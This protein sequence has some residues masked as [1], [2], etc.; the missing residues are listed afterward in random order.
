MANE[1]KIR[2][3]QRTII[4]FDNLT[5]AQMRVQ[6]IIDDHR[7]RRRPCRLIILK[8]RQ[9]GF[10]TLI[11]ANA[12]HMAWS[13]P[14]TRCV[15]TAH[16]SAASNK[17]LYP[18]HTTFLKHLRPEMRPMI[19]SNRDNLL[20]FENPSSLDALN[21]PGL[22]SRI[23]VQVAGGSGRRPEGEGQDAAGIGRGD[24]I[25]FFHGSEVAFWARGAELAD[26]LAQSVPQEPD[27]I[28]VLES[29]G[30]GQAGYFYDEWNR[31]ETGESSFIPVFCA[32][33]EHDEYSAFVL[34]RTLPEWGPTAE[35]LGEFSFYLNALVV[36][37]Q[38]R[39][40]VHARNLRLDDEEEALVR[41]HQLPWDRIK[42]RRWCIIDRCRGR[43]DKFRQ[44]YPSNPQEA[45]AASGQM[46]FNST[47]VYSGLKASEPRVRNGWLRVFGPAGWNPLKDAAD[48]PDI[49]FAGSEQSDYVGDG[50]P[51]F[52]MLEAPEPGRTYIVVAD[53]SEGG[54][55]DEAALVV[56]ERQTRRYVAQLHDDRL[57]P[58]SLAAWAIR[59]GWFYNGALLAP[60]SI[61]VG[62]TTTTYIVNSHYPRVY[63]RRNVGAGD[64]MDV[65]DKW[66]FATDNKTRPRLIDRFDIAIENDEFECRLLDIWQQAR[67]F[68]RYKPKN[69]RSLAR[70]EAA[71]GQKDD[72]LFAAM[73]AFLVNE[74]VPA[75]AT[76][77]RTFS[78]VRDYN[79]GGALGTTDLEDAD[80]EALRSGQLREF[81]ENFYC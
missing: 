52:E 24:Q 35:E 31:A 36:G 74:V 37:D 53:A 5:P 77:A 22:D 41:Q 10:S 47:K 61:G 19:K 60:E 75:D 11:A 18:M 40:A 46:R 1:L 49:R 3:K 26:A 51:L 67:T 72:L 28:V 76:F 70:V 15:I 9:Q 4:P 38:N 56:M 42:W 59:A 66:G 17:A 23:M 8:A 69:Q 13:V 32:W 16:D 71:P 80:E 39:A 63:R 14:G 34:A 68:I 55:G 57:K 45:F 79:W 81:F 44:E 78:A 27:T 43:V 20:H 21:N 25:H 50:D 12:F 64:D 7:K 58:D 48:Q 2:T 30:N 54:G 33:F 73:I 62:V 29:T 6:A 65:Q